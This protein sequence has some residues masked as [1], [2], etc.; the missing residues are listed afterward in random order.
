M[1][2]TITP[3][4]ARTF[5][6]PKKR[7]KLIPVPPLYS[8]FN[9]NPARQP[10]RVVRNNQQPAYGQPCL[11]A[12][13]IPTVASRSA[14]APSAGPA[15]PAPPD[16]AA[17]PPALLD[18]AV[19]AP[20]SP[21]AAAVPFLDFPSS[22]RALLPTPPSPLPH[23]SS[24]PLLPTLSPLPHVPTAGRRRH[25][26]VEFVAR[27]ARRQAQLRLDVSRQ[28]AVVD[29]YTSDEGAQRGRRRISASR[30]RGRSGRLG[31]TR[32]R[33]Q[34]GF[35]PRHG[36]WR[37]RQ[38][39]GE[40]GAEDHAPEARALLEPGAGVGGQTRQAGGGGPRGMVSRR[41][42]EGGTRWRGG[43]GQKGGSVA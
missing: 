19:D 37:R 22:P 14:A 4:V 32:E 35:R 31:G 20:V 1:V 12:E 16:A 40:G 17:G 38:G 26:S 7:K 29:D 41:G 8:S 2:L 34:R 21:D 10:A 36:R 24:S 6:C 11:A 28:D 9:F 13:I 30:G 43:R 23:L 27:L 3:G 42:A 15:T 25:P 33:R 5:V 39:G 18:V